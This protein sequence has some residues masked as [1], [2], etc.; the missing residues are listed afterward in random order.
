MIDRL[1]A[2][3]GAPVL[4]PGHDDYEVSR[5]L[6]NGRV[7]GLPAAIVRCRNANEVATAIRFARDERIEVRVRAG[8]HNPAGQCL[9][10]DVLLIDLR[11]CDAV[12]VDPENRTVTVGGGG[13]WKQVDTATLPHGLAAPGGDCCVVGVAGY[14]LGGG[15]GLLSR[16]YGLGCDNLIGAELVDA[17]GT[18]RWVNNASDADLLWAL[19]G[20]GGNFGAVTK[21]EL[22]LHPVPEVLFAGARIWPVSEAR[23]VMRAYRDIVGAGL[24][25]AFTLCMNIARELFPDGDPCLVVYGAFIGDEA[26]GT[27]LLAPLNVAATPAMDVFSMMPY[28]VVQTLSE[29]DITQRGHGLRGLWK[30]G[31]FEGDLADEAIDAVLEA[32][33]QAPSPT[34]RAHFDFLGGGAVGRVDATATAFP[35]REHTFGVQFLALWPGIDGDEA[36]MAW[37]RNAKAAVAPYLGSGVYSGYGDPDLD[38]WARAYYGGNLE[39]LIDLKRRYDPD[40]VFRFRQGLSEIAG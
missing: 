40:N 19:K 13:L 3:V 24:P 23:D 39:R 16:A 5:G 20:G 6:F 4:V 11:D 7:A 10:D 26:A 9:D 34:C 25:D 15:H 1:A 8:G 37:A 12:D 38:D 14:T 27:E 17:G 28:S 18:I 31:F 36:N 33:A 35:H 32:Y 2:A 29:E 22:D 21:L 30:G